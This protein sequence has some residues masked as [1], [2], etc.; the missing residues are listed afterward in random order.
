MM[1][2][3]YFKSNSITISIQTLIRD[4]SL[5]LFMNYNGRL[6]NS[7]SDFYLFN[8]IEIDSS[9]FIDRDTMLSLQLR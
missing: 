6:P 2:K 3:S 8:K 4:I 5:N 7:L 9:R 1:L